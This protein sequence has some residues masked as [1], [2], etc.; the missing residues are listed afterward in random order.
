MSP[1]DIT[2]QFLTFPE[3]TTTAPVMGSGFLKKKDL[4][5]RYCTGL[6]LANLHCQ[7]LLLK[8]Q[9][10]VWLGLTSLKHLKLLKQNKQTNLPICKF[11]TA[12]LALDKTAKEIA[13]M[14][15]LDEVTQRFYLK[16]VLAKAGLRKG[17]SL[18]SE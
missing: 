10:S 18:D 6:L 4:Y 7:M 14:G 17:F 15:G 11:N 2:K 8:R 13:E 1:N 12:K 9:T 16:D 3:L 5:V